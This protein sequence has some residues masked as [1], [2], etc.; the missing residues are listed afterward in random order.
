MSRKISQ[1]RQT[2]STTLVASALAAV[3]SLAVPS[4]FLFADSPSQ[5][6]AAKPPADVVVETIETQ[7]FVVPKVDA[8]SPLRISADEARKFE[9]LVDLYAYAYPLVLS[10]EIKRETTSRFFYRRP[11]K[12]FIS[13]AFRTLAIERRN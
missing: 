1:R 5:S 6:D 7:R 2:R 4:A 8:E 12:R 11:T 9:A 3:G 10:N 13:R